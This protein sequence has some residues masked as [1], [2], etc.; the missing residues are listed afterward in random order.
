MAEVVNIVLRTDPNQIEKFA[1]EELAAYIR[2]M[3]GKKMNVINEASGKAICV[4]FLPDYVSTGQK[5]QVLN[6]LG[7]L[8]PDGFII[9]SI[10]EGLVIMGRTPRGTLYGVYDYLRMLGVRWYFPGKEHEFVPS[11]GEVILRNVNTMRSPDMNH[12]SIVIHSGNSAL[13]DWVDFAA[14][15]KLNAIHLHS[16]ERIHEMPDIM[17]SR[18]LDFGLR[19]HFFGGVYPP[20]DEAEM[21]RNKSL[22]LDYIRSLPV[23]LN[24]FFLWPADRPLE[25][26]ERELS[27]PDAVLMFTNEMLKAIRTLR[28]DARMSFLVYW[29]TWKAPKTIRPLDG[30]FLEL[31]PIFRCFSHA[32]SDPACPINSKEILPVIGD[33]LQVFDPAEAHVLGYWLDA[34]LFG[35][36]RYKA[37]SGRLPQIGSIIKQDLKY[38][39]SRGIFNISTFAVGI[40]R[41]YLSTY[42]C[43][44]IFQYPALLWDVESDLRSQLMD[45]CENYYGDRGMAEAFQ[46]DEQTDPNDTS[47]VGWD[48]LKDRYARASSIVKEIL[49]GSTDD[50]H[51][52]RLGRL[53]RELE[54]TGSWVDDKTE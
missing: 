48:T 20:P 2:A 8:Q 30:V 45:F 47:V 6:E 43:P 9:R 54:H 13:L 32:I 35:R 41:E 19:R 37:L 39:K 31:A 17:A 11:R 29:S 50:V 14:K 18:G 49:Q 10:G 46:L 36:G 7:A 1:A 16:D 24:E 38:Y 28:P 33:I 40:D 5:E 22:L 4:G 21:D 26:Q 15:V 42:T 51:I 53:M 34:S 44:S 25:L 12:R 27:L 52:Q 3:T 23:Q